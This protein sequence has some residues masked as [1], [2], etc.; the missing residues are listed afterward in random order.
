MTTPK[1]LK[2][3]DDFLELQ[4][5]LISKDFMEAQLQQFMEEIKQAKD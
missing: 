1:D 3:I 4:E 5:T 2:S